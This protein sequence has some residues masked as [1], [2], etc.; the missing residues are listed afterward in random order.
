VASKIGCSARAI[1]QWEDGA[2][3]PAADWL[4]ALAKLFGMS[5]D[6]LWRGPAA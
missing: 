2:R 1:G 5:M 6:E 3:V 4:A